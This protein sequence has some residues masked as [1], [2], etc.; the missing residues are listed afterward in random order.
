MPQ[1]AALL[2]LT[3]VARANAMACSRIET[4][5]ESTCCG[6]PS[7]PS[8]RE[9]QGFGSFP[10]GTNMSME[11]PGSLT[12]RLPSTYSLFTVSSNDGTWRASGGS[13]N[14]QCDC[15]MGGDG[16]GCLVGAIGTRPLCISEGCQVCELLV[17]DGFDRVG[18]PP[19]PPI[20]AYWLRDDASSALLP[21]G[22]AIAPIREIG[23]WSSI[24]YLSTARSASAAFRDA[25]RAFNDTLGVNDDL[26]ASSADKSHVALTYEG[27]KFT[28]VLPS[29]LV[30]GGVL[31][32]RG[33]GG[34]DWVSYQ[35]NC[36][37]SND[38]GDMGC[39]IRN[40]GNVY[41]CVS[42]SC[43]GNCEMTI[44]VGGR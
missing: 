20:A 4:I 42:R 30:G 15:T 7:A 18:A 36:W 35:C 5:Y 21:D 23:T 2:A 25:L 17:Y 10:D 38:G 13:T 6:A 32:S 43:T 11:T 29:A 8:L 41:Y 24:P 37:A 27:E 12:M 44:E 34:N 28:S 1:C 39:D 3:W 22:L 40:E 9:V 16:G 33:T 14:A 19:S 31:H 26:M